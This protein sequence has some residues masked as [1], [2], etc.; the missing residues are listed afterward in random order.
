MKRGIPLADSPAGPLLDRL[1]ALSVVA[2]AIVCVVMLARIQPDERG[3]GTHQQL[4]LPPCGWPQQ[5]GIPCPTCGVTTAA[6]LV[7]HLKPLH[8]I[9]T[10]PF[11]AALALAGVGLACF[12]LRALLL[13]ESLLARISLWPLGTLAATAIALFFAGWGWTWL[14]W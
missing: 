10:Q 13:R 7:V 8:A 2:T 14:R 11:G 1:I 4:G 9:W 6:T 3:H 12:A 5:H